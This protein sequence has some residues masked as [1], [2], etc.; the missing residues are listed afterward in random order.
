MNRLVRYVQGVKFDLTPLFDLSLSEDNPYVNPFDQVINDER[1]DV[2][3]KDPSQV[4]ALCPEE[5]ENY[6]S[7]NTDF[8][9]KV[10]DELGFVFAYFADADNEELARLAWKHIK[11]STLASMLEYSQ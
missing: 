7:E 5:I 1:P 11:D 10:V 4:L 8:K 6:L 9:D 2:S 3:L